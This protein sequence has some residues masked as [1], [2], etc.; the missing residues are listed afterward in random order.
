MG[1]AGMGVHI[2][3]L[4]RELLVEGAVHPRCVHV[5]PGGDDEVAS[6]PEAEVPHRV[7]HFVLVVMPGAPVS[8]GNE[9]KIVMTVQLHLKKNFSKIVA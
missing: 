3:P 5:V 6:V 2:F 1:N 4:L 7:R 8:D 9:V